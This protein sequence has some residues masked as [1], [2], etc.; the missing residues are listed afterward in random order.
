MK[1]KHAMLVS[2]LMLITMLL[3]AEN[4]IDTNFKN[5]NKVCFY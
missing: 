2:Y 1:K 4:F 3:S 5:I